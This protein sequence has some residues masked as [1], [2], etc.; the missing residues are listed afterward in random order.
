METPPVVPPAPAVHVTPPAPP[1]HRDL[2]HKMYER[3]DLSADIMAQADDQNWSPK[4]AL[5]AQSKINAV[6]VG[7]GGKPNVAGFPLFSHRLDSLRLIH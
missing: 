4:M 7:V 6:N 2:I 1:N 3:G 5:E